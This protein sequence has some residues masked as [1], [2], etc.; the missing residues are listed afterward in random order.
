MRRH[1]IILRLGS[2]DSDAVSTGR[3]VDVVTDLPFLDNTQPA[4]DRVTHDSLFRELS[5]LGL[6]PTEV[7]WDLLLLAVAVFAADTNINRKKDSQDGWTR[8]IDLYVPV[9]SPEMWS[10]SAPDLEAALRFLSGDHWRIVF[11][12]RP[13][14]LEAISRQPKK[15]IPYT[16]KTIC[17]FSGGLDS[18]VGA[19]DLLAMNT[20]PLLVGHHKSPDVNHPQQ[21]CLRHLETAYP[22]TKPALVSAYVRVPKRIFGG[23]Q[24]KN[25]RARSF[26]FLSLGVAVA[27][28]L[29]KKSR[30]VLPEN[31]LISLNTSLTPLRIGALST[32]TTHPHFV[33]TFQK[34]V[35]SAGL[36]VRIENPYQF[37]T[38]GE[39]LRECLDKATLKKGLL[40]TMSCAHP[41]AKRYRG[42][43][44]RHCGRCVPC[45]I[46]R[47]AIRSAFS[48]DPTDYSIDVRSIKPA[49]DTADGKDV[50][51]FEIALSRLREH[52]DMS[53]FVIHE[54]GPLPRDPNEL[55]KFTDVFERGM[56]EMG[57][58]LSGK[59]LS[60]TR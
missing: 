39:M 24:D 15:D 50:R 51:A 14:G 9:K 19:L 30:L 6:R 43:T 23:N 44:T 11:R 17:L 52:P 8:E 58:L 25:E 21:V 7:A 28:S 33:S 2:E 48:K 3:D 45:L 59:H 41:T 55:E 54:S 26:L 12:Q 47:A 38:K 35:D 16:T 37:K 18:F 29:G 42:E 31:G 4:A 56:H 1:A 27:S 34:I 32:R 40:D 46:R 57:R 53:R 13:E 5:R 22:E 10:Q 49:A 36:A 60:A 20:R